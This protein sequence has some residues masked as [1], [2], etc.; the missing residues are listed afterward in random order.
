MSDDVIRLP[1]PATVVEATEELRRAT[2]LEPVVEQ[3]HSRKWRITVASD[4]VTTTMDFS[5][6]GHRCRWVGSTLAVDGVSRPLVDTP[7]EL[8]ELFRHPDPVSVVV[9]PM[10]PAVPVSE[11][12]VRVRHYYAILASSPLGRAATITIGRSPKHWV[13]GFDLAD[14]VTL[15]LEF[16]GK[17]WGLLLVVDGVDRS[18]EIDGELDQALA[19]IGDALGEPVSG[20]SSVP[21]TAPAARSNPVEVRR[22]TVI[23]V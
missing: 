11:A 17:T 22:N 5:V 4:R 23:R 18:R 20:S 16:H 12:P 10:P 6:Q 2:A 8:G 19:L 3:P 7:E 15:R 9:E 13:I 21:G 14:R 1:M